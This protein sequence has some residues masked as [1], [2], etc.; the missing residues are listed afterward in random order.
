MEQRPTS[1]VE[2]RRFGGG[3]SG[4]TLVELLVAALLSLVLM[5]ATATLFSFFSRAARQSQATVDLSN[6]L[7]SAAWQL[8][9][10]LTGC[11]SS[12]A[13]WASPSTNSGY[14][15]LVE[16]PARDDTAAIIDGVPTSNLAADTDDI[17]LFTTQALAEPFVGRFGDA[18]AESPYAEVSW[19][20]R[21]LPQAQQNIPGTVLCKLHRRQLLVINY[22]GSLDLPDNTLSAPSPGVDRS[23]YDVSLRQVPGTVA[24]TTLFP[25]SLGDLAKRE[26]RFLRSGYGQALQAAPGWRAVSPTA[27]P[28]P[29]PREAGT[30]YAEP[31]AS[32]DGTLRDWEDVILTNVI[33]FD[34]RVYDPEA[35]AVQVGST[36]LLPGDPGYAPPDDGGVGAG[37]YVDLGW[38]EGGRSFDKSLFPP[39]QQTTFGSRGFFTMWPPDDELL[40]PDASNSTKYANWLIR[41]ERSFFWNSKTMVAVSGAGGSFRNDGQLLCKAV[42]MQDVGGLLKGMAVLGEGI[43]FG[44]FVSEVRKATNEVVVTNYREDLA[45]AIAVSPGKYLGFY[46][47][48]TTYDTWSRHYEFNNADDDLD[49]V[50]DDGTIGVDADGDGYP[51][52]SGE[53]ETSPPYPVPLRGLEVRIRCYEPVSK[54]VRQITVRHTFVR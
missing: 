54:Q 35:R 10:D 11:T 23:R 40:G 47:P 27:F 49:G 45:A 28:Y 51:E 12:V 50:I 2:T 46:L 39:P 17:L 16:G 4:F 30:G 31:V 14:F 34:V 13:P 21:P 18:S 33:G 1:L 22:L 5:G 3:R 52:Y 32:L 48:A 6:L 26:N 41:F 25:N 44:T 19:F 8:K 42:R 29:L 7:R 9:Q 37:A 36:W 38:S 53:N 43:P 24:N 20:C 15:E